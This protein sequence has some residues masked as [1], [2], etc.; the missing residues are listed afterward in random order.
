MKI[1][2]DFDG[3]VADSQTLK[4]LVAKDM[5][6]VNLPL[7]DCTNERVIRHGLSLDDYLIVKEAIYHGQYTINPVENAIFYLR[8]LVEQGYDPRIVT[9][10]KEQTLD[11][12]IGWFRS[13][14]I[15]LP[16]K[17]VGYKGSKVEACKG[18]DLYVDDDLEK[19]IPLIGEVPHL[20]LFSWPFNQDDPIPNGIGRVR[21]WW[22]IYNY[23]RYEM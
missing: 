23:V 9:S 3:V 14:S 4:P 1:A 7:E 21:S 11:L 10:R 17:G 16:I 22:E 8:T 2:F 5:F 13:H 15:D 6:R 18:I 19:L 12:A 20:L